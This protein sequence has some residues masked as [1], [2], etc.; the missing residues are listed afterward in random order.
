MAG[1]TRPGATEIG[2]FFGKRRTVIP[3]LTVDD[4]LAEQIAR[5]LA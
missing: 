2:R 4:I 3:P 5:R 1:P